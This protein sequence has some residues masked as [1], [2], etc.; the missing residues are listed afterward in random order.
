MTS[1]KILVLSLVFCLIYI[2]RQSNDTIN[3]QKDQ[4]FLKIKN[5]QA[6]TVS[7]LLYLY[8]CLNDS[9]ISNADSFYASISTPFS[10]IIRAKQNTKIVRNFIPQSEHVYK[11]Y[12][13]LCHDDGIMNAP[14]TLPNKPFDTLFSHSWYGYSGVLGQMPAKGLCQ[15]CDS[16]DI[17]SVISWMQNNK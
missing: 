14:Y 1:K 16:T 12:C 2:A 6:A 15:E 9:L 4:K 3:I 11:K 13:I 5:N 10:E 17:A 8:N 7:D